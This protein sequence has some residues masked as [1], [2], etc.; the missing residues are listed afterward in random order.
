MAFLIYTLVFVL[1]TVPIGIFLRFLDLGFKMKN[2]FYRTLVFP[3]EVSRIHFNLYKSVRV[4]HKKIALHLLFA[5][6]L[7]LPHVIISVAEMHLDT[8]AKFLAITELLQE[9]G[10]RDRNKLIKELKKQGILVKR[11][12]IKEPKQVM[13]S[14]EAIGTYVH[15]LGVKG[16]LELSE[17][18]FPFKHTLS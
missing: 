17:D 11:K 2:A 16:N 1:L 3:I 4:K 6:I 15:N 12:K 18:I 8:Q 5:P 10:E 9:L 13:N 7:N 14:D